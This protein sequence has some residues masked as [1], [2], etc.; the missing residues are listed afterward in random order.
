MSITQTIDLMLLHL[1][2][3]FGA[4]SIHVSYAHKKKL[5]K[6]YKGVKI[7]YSLSTPQDAVYIK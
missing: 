5:G 1:P 7:E 6:E 2:K 4:K 3:E